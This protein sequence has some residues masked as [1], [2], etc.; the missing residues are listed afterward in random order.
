[1]GHFPGVLALTEDGPPTV[2]NL[3]HLGV[4]SAARRRRPT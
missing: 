4:T 2:V 1:M 3:Q